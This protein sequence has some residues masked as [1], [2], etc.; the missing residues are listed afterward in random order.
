VPAGWSKIVD[1]AERAT[2]VQG[3]ATNGGACSYTGQGVLHV[4]RDSYGVSGCKMAEFVKGYSILDAAIEAEFGMVKGCGGMWMR[5]GAVGYFVAVCADGTVTLHR[6]A[7]DP[8][9]IE[10]QLGPYWRPGFTKER[11]IVGLLAQGSTLTLY[12]DGVAQT[13]VTDD[14]IPKGRLGVGGFGPHPDD[15]VDATITRFRVWQPGA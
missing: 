5:T 12:I 9:S 15:R 13:S 3:E 14:T 10:T 2:V 7:D 1:D 4:S 6:L 8:P 11:V